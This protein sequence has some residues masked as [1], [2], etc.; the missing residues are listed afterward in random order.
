MTES[1][2]IT[3]PDDTWY[4]ISSV[5]DLTKQG[6]STVNGKVVILPTLL[7]TTENSTSCLLISN[8]FPIL[9]KFNESM[10]YVCCQPWRKNLP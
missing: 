5:F 3:H 4:S 10:S 2:G 8:L 9:A 6:S 7:W 1:E